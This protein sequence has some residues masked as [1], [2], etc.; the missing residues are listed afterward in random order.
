MNILRGL[1]SKMLLLVLVVA[2]MA[3]AAS[4]TFVSIQQQ[5]SLDENI[6]SIKQSH[7]RASRLL[8]AH[9]M[10][11]QILSAEEIVLLS[12]L[13]Q[14][15]NED[16]N[17]FFSNVWPR[18][19][20]NFSLSSMSFA[21]QN[22]AFTFGQFP[23][24]HMSHIQQTVSTQLRPESGIFCHQVCELLASVPVNYQGDTW[25]LSLLSD[26]APSVMLLNSVV[27]SNIG[28]LSPFKQ[29]NHNSSTLSRYETDLMTGMEATT[30]LFAYE[31]TESQFE[32]L[33]TKG[34]LI[35]LPKTDYFVWFEKIPGISEDL[36]IMFVQDVSLTLMQ[37]REQKQ[38]VIIIFVTLTF[39]ILLFLILFS[40][41]PIAKINQLKRAIKLIGA[42]EYNIARYRLGKSR[43]LLIADELD[44]LKDEFRHAIDVL[45]TYEQ[46][47]TNSQKRLVRQA[48]I[49]SITG[50]FTRNVLIEDLANMNREEH[51]A[52]VAIFFLDL[53]G[54]K[55]VNDN[56]G[57]EAGDIML[58]KIGY[59]LKGVVNK[60]IRVYR[61][62]GDEFVICYSNYASQDTLKT[63]AES[64]VELFSAPF[65]IYDTSISI[66][67]SI[68]IAFQEAHAIEPDRLLRY[69][70][71]AMYQAKKDGKNCF[72]FF[73]EEMR[74]N[75]QRRFTIKND[76]ITALASG[77]LYMVFQPIVSARSRQVTKLEALCRWE[78]PE[79]G[80]IPPLV[81][82]DVLEESENM[83]IL[84]EWIVGDI[85][86]EIAYI[87]SVGLEDIVVSINLSPSQLVND[88]ALT[89][90]TTMCKER[91][92]APS[93]IELEIT[94]TSL[95]TN[96]EQAKDWV[97]DATEQGFKIAI[98]DF[99]AGYSSLSYLTAFPYDTVKLDRSLLYNIDIDDRQQRIVGS[100]TQMLHGL[101]VPIVAEGAET[102]AHFEQLRL[103]GCDY[104]QGY[105][106]SRPIAHNDLAAFLAQQASPD[107][108]IRVAK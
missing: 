89:L 70:D 86:D 84:F 51:I 101:S 30:D 38:Q 8:F 81:F 77:Q 64:V 79:L 42:K 55:P 23:R 93:R 95:I 58:K 13:A 96:F 48:T 9:E 53:D 49:D 100:L 19:Q 66:S 61:I 26:L 22:Q 88:E 6:E 4:Y 47:L 31:L 67:A 16:I 33:E 1:L 72:T 63:M 74:Q 10:Q 39:G 105:L 41:I 57:H 78:H 3:L 18:I 98:D 75:T 97:E 62:G 108:V 92:V 107:S 60:F 91:A 35:T 15:R 90:L 11:E 104:I 17:T 69:A 7:L 83:N 87:D 37:Q 52:N 14:M 46:E 76:F 54:F 12:A 44:D 40:I 50:L 65:H 5:Q 29:H 43:K 27:G 45:E 106:I 103:L 21:S 32:E 73:N 102:E 94:E 36:T 25:S 24:Q 82:I 2:I 71:I 20:L 59:R 28:I 85:L 99:G 68:G 34:L 80:H 56:L